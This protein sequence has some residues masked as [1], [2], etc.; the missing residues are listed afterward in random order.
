M[1]VNFLKT[2][3]IRSDLILEVGPIASRSFVMPARE[4]LLSIQC[5]HVRGRDSAGGSANPSANASAPHAIPATPR[6]NMHTKDSRK[7]R[8]FFLH[9][10]KYSISPL[11]WVGCSVAVSGGCIKPL[12][13][14]LFSMQKSR[15]TGS[16]YYSEILA[17]GEGYEPPEG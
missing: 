8:Q 12:P 15:M 2:S 7:R 11:G 14:G 16:L 4:M 1:A 3:K 10:S 6:E 5:H 17:E 9:V 13:T